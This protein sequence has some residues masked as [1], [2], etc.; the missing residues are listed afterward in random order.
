[1]YWFW[2]ALFVLQ[3]ILVIPAYYGLFGKEAEQAAG[4]AAVLFGVGLLVLVVAFIVI[5]CM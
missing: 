2:I 3:P 1:M 4:D 5:A